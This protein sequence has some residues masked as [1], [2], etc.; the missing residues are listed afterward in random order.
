LIFNGTDEA[1]TTVNFTGNEGANAITGALLGSN[2]LSG[3]AGADQLT[4]GAGN[5]K[6]DGGS[7][8]DRM[9]GGAGNDLYIVDS[10]L[11]KVLELEN[12]GTDT[13]Q[14]DLSGLVLASNVENLT[15]TGIGKFVGTGNA[16]DNMI[17]GGAGN[18]L[19]YGREGN[20][21]L[22][23]NAGNDGLSGGL[24]DDTLSGGD[25]ND[26]LDG[27]IG[28]DGLNGGAGNDTLFG[29]GG[30]DT[31]TGGEGADVLFGG[32]GADFFDF[33]SLSG[34]DAIKDFSSAQGDKLMLDH[35]V[36]GHAVDQLSMGDA[37]FVSGAGLTS[38]QTADQHFVFNSSTGA[39]Y[40]DADGSGDAAAQL[41]ANFAKGTQLAAADFGFM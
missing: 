4:A 7:G 2:T 17:T 15:Y 12:G 19:L 24:G 23:G 13:V 30:N 25:G 1:A 28:N 10:I 38:A 39:L 9:E 33:T 21:T 29:L 6:L 27:G 34:V 37:E 36:F 3:G 26:G 22:S 35:L 32:E 40:Y 31:L 11:D 8:A 5:D 16:L 20:D 18:D 41:I 14:T